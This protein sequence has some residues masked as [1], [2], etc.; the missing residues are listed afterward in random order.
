[1]AR[2][3]IKAV[4]RPVQIHG[5]EV[6]A[7]KVVLPS[8]GLNHHE[9]GLL[10]YPVGRVGLLGIA[11]PEALFSKWHRRELGVGAYRADL[12]EFRHPLR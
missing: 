6:D 5:Q 3:W 8:I 2:L 12:N 1:M 9:Q 11:V 4:P 10:G 7:R